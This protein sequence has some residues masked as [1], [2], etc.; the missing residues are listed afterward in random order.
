MTIYL[1]GLL[2]VVAIFI[3]TRNRKD[4][5]WKIPQEAMPAKWK[6]ILTKEITFYNSL[7]PTEK[8]TSSTF[9]LINS[10]YSVVWGIS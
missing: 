5:G 6:A 8:N 10:T 2:G 3:V 9:T 4:L 1:I 7:S